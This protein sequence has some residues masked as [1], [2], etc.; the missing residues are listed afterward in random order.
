[1]LDMGRLILCRSASRI[2]VFG[3]FVMEFVI[4]IIVVVVNIITRFSRTR[5]DAGNCATTNGGATT[6][7]TFTDGASS[8]TTV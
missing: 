5:I 3:I 6:T 2:F 8:S 1:M 7:A 4:I